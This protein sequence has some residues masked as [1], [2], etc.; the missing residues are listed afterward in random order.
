MPRRIFK[1]IDLNGSKIG[2]YTGNSP[3]QA[4]NKAFSALANSG[5]VMLYENAEIEIREV[6]R[7]SKKKSYGYS[8]QR[9]ELKQPVVIQV[10]HNTQWECK[11]KNNIKRVFD[12]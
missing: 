10:G 1:L 6:T 11:Y 3:F 9:I 8:C 7:G 5:K 4:A 12:N 2:H